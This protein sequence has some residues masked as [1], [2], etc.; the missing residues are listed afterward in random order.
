MGS[1]DQ[2]AV[3]VLRASTDL[4]ELES[5]AVSITIVL[6]IQY[7][8]RYI[9]IMVFELRYQLLT[10]TCMYTNYTQ[11][12]CQ[13]YSFFVGMCVSYCFSLAYE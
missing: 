3:S 12:L 9:I 4:L 5:A 13:T 2:A 8:L 1:L 6:T 7:L 11:P 10:H